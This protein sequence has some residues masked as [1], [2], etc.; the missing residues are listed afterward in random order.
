MKSP[1]IVSPKVE[2]HVEHV[3]PKPPPVAETEEHSFC[4][5]LGVGLDSMR[6]VRVRRSPELA[7][8]FDEA[9]GKLWDLADDV[10]TWVERGQLGR[11]KWE[12]T[13]LWSEQQLLVD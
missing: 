2:E 12:G 11:N 6:E 13:G 4:P 8:R 7:G 1:Q 5:K 10:A 9:M 3:H